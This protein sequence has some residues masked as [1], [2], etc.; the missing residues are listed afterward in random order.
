MTEGRLPPVSS[1]IVSRS[2]WAV[3]GAA[4]S[5]ASCNIYTDALLEPDPRLDGGAGNGGSSGNAGSGGTGAAGGTDC[6]AGACWWSTTTPE[7]CAD[8]RAPTPADRPAPTGGADVPVFYIAIDRVWFG[9]SAPVNHPSGA[10]PWQFFGLNLDGTCTNAPNCADA[11]KNEVACRA[12]IGVPP[13]GFGCRDNMFARLQPVAAQ[14]PNLGRP[15]GITEDAFNCELHRGSF[16]ILIKVSGYN[17][18]EDDDQVRL[19]FFMSPGLDRTLDDWSCPSSDWAAR[20]PWLANFPWRVDQTMLSGS[21]PS[22]ELPS[23]TLNDPDAY[24]RDG[25]LV[26]DLPNAALMRFI[27]DNADSAGFAMLLD[28]GVFVARPKLGNDGLWTVEDGLLAGSVTQQNMLLAFN[29]MGLCAGGALPGGGT[30]SQ[31][32]A[33]LLSDYLRGNMD[34]LRA[35]GKNPSTP[36]DS[37]SV[38]I[39][40][41][42]RQAM[43]G[44]GVEVSTLVECPNGGTPSRID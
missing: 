27:A 29:Q 10:D 24:V 11:P 18:T 2:I 9:E 7:G 3:A 1:R 16:S 31:A 42:G 39:A 36:C 40:F 20:A 43:P 37:M 33:N 13:D 12:G 8:H 25:Y 14:H 17:G 6:A 32:E 28:G 5:V 22:G 19:D 35:R 38:G 4:L 30:I 41:T 21:A 44:P 26:G 23:S 15:F 34:M